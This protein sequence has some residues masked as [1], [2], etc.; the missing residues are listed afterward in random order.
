MKMEKSGSE[1]R[2]QGTATCARDEGGEVGPVSTATWSPR[3]QVATA[4]KYKKKR[5]ASR[6]SQKTD[7]GEK[8]R[9][10]ERERKKRK[11]KR[12]RRERERRRRRRRRRRKRKR[13]C[14]RKRE[15]KEKEKGNRGNAILRK[16]TVSRIKEMGG[17]GDRPESPASVAGGASRE[18]VSPRVADPVQPA[19]MQQ[20]AEF[21][22]NVA[23][24]APRRSAIE[25]L[26]KHRPTDFHGRND[27]DASAAE[28]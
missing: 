6:R 3:P 25:R 28:Y 9:D 8:E 20:M 7:R 27:E 22:Q 1:Q 19:F 23:R 12:E 11:K 15:G 13:K 5:V 16:E 2:D 21:F 14:R 26:A 4:E 10:R 18:S 17:S 24:A